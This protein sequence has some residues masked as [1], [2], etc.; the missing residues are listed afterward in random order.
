MGLIS[1]SGT[2]SGVAQGTVQV[3]GDFA[4]WRLDHCYSIQFASAS[5]SGHGRDGKRCKCA[6]SLAATLTFT[7]RGGWGGRLHLARKRPTRLWVE[8]VSDAKGVPWC[9]TP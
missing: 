9:P 6:A 8:I 5:G 3:N 2:V 1:A 4:R 7:T